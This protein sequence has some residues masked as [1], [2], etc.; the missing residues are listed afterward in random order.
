M[1]P[2]Q[3]KAL[4]LEASELKHLDGFIH[5]HAL[6]FLIGAIYLLLALLV[7]VLCGALRRKGGQSTHH[8]RTVIFIELPGTPPPPAEPPFDPFPPMREP[9]YYDHDDYPLD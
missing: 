7:W 6:Y 5:E 4:E 2:W 9:D 1:Q 8:V 3:I